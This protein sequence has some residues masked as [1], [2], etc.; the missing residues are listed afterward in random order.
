[1]VRVADVRMAG[2]AA[3]RSAAPSF[4]PLLNRI[5]SA[6]IAVRV[7]EPA[8]IDLRGDSA[9]WGTLVWAHGGSFVRGTLDWPEADWASRR[10]AEAG[11]RVYSVDYVLASE[12]VKAPAPAND[13][14]AVLRQVRANHVG[15]VFVGGASAGGHLAV[16]AALAQAE[17]AA[18]AGDPAARP[19]GLA[20]VYPTLHRVQRPDAAISALT[21]SLAEERRF[22]EERIAEMYDFYLGSLDED[23]AAPFSL[24]VAGEL[25]AQ[26]LALLPPTVIVNAES[27]DLRASAEQ[28]AE[29]LRV[30]GVAVTETAQ[31]GTV[32]GYLNRPEES[33]RATSD[34]QTTIG[35]IVTGLLTEH[36]GLPLLPTS[37]PDPAHKRAYP[38][39]YSRVF[40]L[41]FFGALL[42]VG[43]L[44]GLV[45]AA[46][47]NGARKSRHR[48]AESR[49]WWSA[50]GAHRAA[51]ARA[52]R[53]T[54]LCHP[55]RCAGVHRALR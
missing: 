38:V 43:G 6:E 53:R 21:A 22:G 55:A 23:P 33:P 26:R 35:L 19:D 28:F 3:G 46:F 42:A 27:D 20:L 52:G 39:G 30:A 32:H 1:M 25:P 44:V 2:P 36:A 15:P 8:P 18:A 48:G 40:L 49:T 5:G 31:P 13:I 34:A 54:N 41:S 45:F 16:L 47:M 17:F 4:T 10:F 9:P 14:T 50:R 37:T 11:L 12:T 51:P 29:Q 24:D 7:Y